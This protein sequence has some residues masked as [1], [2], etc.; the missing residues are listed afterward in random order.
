LSVTV[1]ET[2]E[3]LNLIREGEQFI[4]K[5]LENPGHANNPVTAKAPDGRVS[6]FDKSSPL[7][8]QL[9]PNQKVRGAIK[10]VLTSSIIVTP[11]EVLGSV[12]PLDNGYPD[13]I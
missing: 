12:E 1:E 3:E 7:T 8:K 10:T 11:L 13:S 6:L 2:Y 4:F 9:K 5:T